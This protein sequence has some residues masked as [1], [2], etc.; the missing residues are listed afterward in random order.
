MN[1]IL[2]STAS[3]LLA[4]KIH[5]VLGRTNLSLRRASG[6]N[7]CVVSGGSQIGSERY[8]MELEKAS[9]DQFTN[10]T[11]G[12]HFFFTIYFLRN[13][14]KIQQNVIT[15]LLPDPRAAGLHLTF[16]FSYVCTVL[17]SHCLFV[18]IICLSH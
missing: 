16:Q 5:T 15:R 3:F 17:R 10:N 18:R 12:P 1:F 11:G 14:N 6:P 9:L 7:V 2:L 4:L 13:G 8:Q